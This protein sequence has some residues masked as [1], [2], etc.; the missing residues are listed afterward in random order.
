MTSNHYNHERLR[1]IRMQ[2]FTQE[3]IARLVGVNVK[4]I[5][6]VETGKSA[7]FELL[8]RIMRE[9]GRPVKEIIY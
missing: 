6:R 3:Q 7:S 5:S 8:S 9:C 2:R 4:T 1:E